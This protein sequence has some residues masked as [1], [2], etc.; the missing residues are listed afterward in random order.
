M[1]TDLGGLPPTFIA[2]G[3]LDLFLE[4]SVDFAL[5]ASRA[6]VAVEG[7]VYPGAVHGFDLLGDTSIAKQFRFDQQ[8]A[9]ARWFRQW[10]HITKGTR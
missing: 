2:V 7:H 5:R 3:A 10:P 4:E 8:Q 9:F 1:A 6:G